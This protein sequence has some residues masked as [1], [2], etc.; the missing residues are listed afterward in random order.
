MMDQLRV[1]SSP[2]VHKLWNIKG[3]MFN[4]CLALLPAA[5]YGVVQFG[6]NAA[7]VMVS[8]VAS[9]VLT[10]WIIGILCKKPSTIGDFSAAVTGMLIGMSCP[11][12]APFWIPMIGSIFAIGI[13]K[14]LFGGL[15]YN[16]MNPALAARAVLLASWP[17]IMTDWQFL[18][19]GAAASGA[20]VVSQATPLAAAQ[21]GTAASYSD[22]FFGSVAGCIGEV[23]KLLLLV[24][25]AYLV[26]TK[27]ISLYTPMGVLG[28]LFVLTWAL[29]GEGGLF[30]GDGLYAILSGAAILCAFFM[31]TD[32]T[33][34]PVTKVGQVVFG[35]GVG[36]MIFVIR[37]YGS[38]PEGVTYAVLFMN[39]LTPMI[40]KFIRPRIYG[41]VKSRG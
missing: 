8:A 12:T 4:V 6:L 35:I 2:H 37:T 5:I 32:Y 10:E 27:V 38:Y 14:Q 15:G 13:V 20:T 39:I 25:A 28:S 26:I 34:S 11:P 24:G 40:D 30:T 36:A 21:Y 31:A 19:T 41:E 22:L 1:S 17:S 7:V 3:I 18:N 23:S 29:G 16:F 33:T 9:A